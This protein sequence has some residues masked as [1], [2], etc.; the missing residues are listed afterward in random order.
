M[1]ASGV[2]DKGGDMELFL[3]GVTCEEAV[4]ASRN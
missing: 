2:L 3:S 4:L 1:I